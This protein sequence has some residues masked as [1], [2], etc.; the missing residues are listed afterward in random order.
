MDD[1]DLTAQLRLLRSP[2][3]ERGSGL[4]R[5]AAAMFFYRHNMMDAGALE[6]YRAFA[7]EDTAD[8]LPVA[9]AQ[10]CALDVAITMPVKGDAV[11]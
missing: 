1:P 9:L 11:L 10:G 4:V 8:A 2:V 6:V 7:K 5:Y 3:G